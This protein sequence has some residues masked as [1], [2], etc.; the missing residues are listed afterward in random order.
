MQ[1]IASVNAYIDKLLD[2]WIAEINLQTAMMNTSPEK[3]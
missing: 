1:Q 2:F 3:D